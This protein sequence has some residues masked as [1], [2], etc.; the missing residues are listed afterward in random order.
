[1][2]SLGKFSRSAPSS[3]TTGSTHARC[4]MART[5]RILDKLTLLR[6]RGDAGIAVLAQLRAVPGMNVQP[7]AMFLPGL[8]RR[9]AR[10][11]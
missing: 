8:L 2:C 10:F 4:T 5:F 7:R 3:T 1:M 11:K 6:S 9:A